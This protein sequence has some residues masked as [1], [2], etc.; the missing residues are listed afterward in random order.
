MSD[1]GVSMID[2][3]GLFG[4]NYKGQLS[5]GSIQV[6]CPFCDTANSRRYHM[7]INLDKNV[8]FCPRCMDSSWKHTGTL[9]LYGRIKYNEP[10]KP[11]VNGK[12]LYR[13]LMNDLNRGNDFQERTNPTVEF[14]AIY[15]QSDEVLDRAYQELTRCEFLQLSEKHRNNLK[16]RGMS[17]FAIANNGYI[18]FPEAADLIAKVDPNGK[19]NAFYEEKGVFSAAAENPMLK[20]KKRE[21]IV[22]GLIVARYIQS[23]KCVID[24]VPGFYELCDGIWCF[25]YLPGMMIPTRNIKGQIIA[26]QIRLDQKK[27]DGNRYLTISSK[28][29]PHGPTEQIAR[30]HFRS[31][32]K[33][34]SDKTTVLLTEGPLK[35]DIILDFAMAKKP[36]ADVAI[37]AIQGV[38]N[39]RELPEMVRYLVD[40]G[41]KVFWNVMDI[42][43][44]CNPNVNRA[45]YNIDEIFRNNGAADI[46]DW[47]WDV[48]YAYKLAAELRKLCAKIAAGD[49]R[50]PIQPADNAELNPFKDIESMSRALLARE[51][52]DI[53]LRF[54]SR[55][56]SS[57]DKKLANLVSGSRLKIEWRPEAKGFD[58][59]ML[60]QRTLGK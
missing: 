35:G 13:R 34:V 9:D 12:E 59:W 31:S 51:N 14:K 40:R 17:D 52:E 2:L 25:R 39:V 27:K 38:N 28:G 47:K 45:M 7:N 41:A 50:C 55:A 5:S 1:P 57:E 54:I 48:E 60:L 37:V 36:N 46:D 32:K 44:Y 19:F 42:D 24:R 15:P 30:T 6:Q 33:E 8:Y 3:I 29:F 21:D 20:N 23:K 4:L 58:D 18:T 16:K 49:P 10:L 43:R 53:V 26:A 22:A 11:G 56:R